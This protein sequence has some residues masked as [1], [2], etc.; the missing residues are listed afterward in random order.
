M[1]KT[2]SLF[3]L[4]LGASLSGCNGGSA[5][6]ETEGST[7]ATSIV[8]TNSGTVGA[9]D[10]TTT[11]DDPTGATGPTAPTEATTDDTTAASTGTQGDTG[12]TEPADDT[13][14]D[15]GT[16][17]D[18]TGDTDTTGPEEVCAAPR[19]YIT[20]DTALDAADPLAP[21][22][23]LGLGCPGDASDSIAITDTSFNSVNPNAWRIATG[24]G[25]YH[26]DNDPN[27]PLYFSPREGGAFLMLST[28]VVAQPDAAGVVIEAAKSQDGNG[29]NGNDDGDELP[30][31]FSVVPGSNAG[32]GGTPFLGCDG[33]GDCS[34]TL[35]TQWALGESNPNDKLWFSFKTTVPQGTNGYVFNFAYCSA[36]YPMYIDYKYN[37]MV[38]AWQN[39]EAYTGN[40]TFVK[41]MDQELPLTVTS[42]APYLLSDGFIGNEPQLK[43]TG[44]ETRGCTAWF[45][46]KGGVVP[47][48]QITFGVLAADM[49]DSILATLAILDN[50]RWDCD[51]CVPSETDS[52]GVDPIPG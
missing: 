32:A 19:R 47:G 45:S 17:A 33:V 1:T 44:F 35:Q 8:V 25:S 37:D 24:F 49:G 15:T 46:A 16:T 9:T 51:G 40:V 38:V 34:D 52:C 36:E 20:C 41:Y 5:G 13:T 12:T 42:L 10:G 4:S 43:G 39:S 29:N 6:S 18:D 30:A 48:E 27:K 28:G 14:G 2:S 23:A 21:F 11:I 22:Q 50:W 7:G 31:P 26:E 3:V